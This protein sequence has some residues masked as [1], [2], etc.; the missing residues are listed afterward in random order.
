MCSAFK[1]EN[2]MLTSSAD[3]NVFLFFLLLFL[4]GSNSIPTRR[5]EGSRKFKE[6]S[7]SKNKDVRICIKARKVSVY[8][9]PNHFLRVHIRPIS[10]LVSFTSMPDIYTLPVNVVH[11][12]KVCFII[13]SHLLISLLCLYSI[14]AKYHKL[15]YGTELNQGEVKMPSFESG[16]D[17]SSLNC[18]KT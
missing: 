3:P 17:L 18:N 7:S 15:K 8:L 13:S 4:S 5:K 11:N 6:W 10:I 2:V 14:R 9:L 16:T 12:C 1:V